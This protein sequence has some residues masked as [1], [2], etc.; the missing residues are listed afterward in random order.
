MPFS[1]ASGELTSYLQFTMKLP[2][3]LKTLLIIYLSFLLFPQYCF[4]IKTIDTVIE[5]AIIRTTATTPPRMAPGLMVFS[6]EGSGL[7]VE[8]TVGGGVESGIAI[9]EHSSSLNDEICTEHLVSTVMISP[10]TMI[11]APPLTQSSMR[12]M[13]EPLS[14]SEVPWSLARYVT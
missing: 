7:R 14:V 5:M 10:V 6:V 2:L 13:S 1:E 4:T 11:S 8:S 9:L 3:L 12:E